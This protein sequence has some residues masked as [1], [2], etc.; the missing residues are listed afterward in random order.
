MGDEKEKEEGRKAKK[1]GTFGEKVQKGVRDGGEGKRKGG[2]WWKE[3]E[4]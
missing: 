3:R 1:D 2:K 4:K